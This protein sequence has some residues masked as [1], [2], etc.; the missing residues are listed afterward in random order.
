MIIAFIV[1]SF[2]LLLV[3]D[4]VAVTIEHAPPNTLHSETWAPN[5]A[6]HP[7]SRHGPTWE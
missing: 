7:A 2:V 3:I 6:C 5:P 1:S 4:K